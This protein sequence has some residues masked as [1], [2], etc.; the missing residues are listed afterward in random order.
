MVVINIIEEAMATQYLIYYECPY[1]LS[2][3]PHLSCFLSSLFVTVPCTVFFDITGI[4]LL[5]FSFMIMMLRK[6]EFEMLLWRA[7]Q[8]SD[9]NSGMMY[10]Y[11]HLLSL[12]FRRIDAA[13][14]VMVV[15]DDDDSHLTRTNNA[16]KHQKHIFDLLYIYSFEYLSTREHLRISYNECWC[17]SSNVSLCIFLS[18]VLKFL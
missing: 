10:M 1:S 15:Y 11:V 5:L 13:S 18:I 16:K 8:N 12:A 4:F 6:E 17:G 14:C 9:V 2:R 3:H 7:C